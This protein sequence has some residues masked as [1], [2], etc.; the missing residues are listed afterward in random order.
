MPREDAAE[1]MKLQLVRDADDDERQEGVQWRPQRARIPQSK[2][3]IYNESQ[4]SCVFNRDWLNFKPIFFVQFSIFFIDQ[5]TGWECSEASQFLLKRRPN[6]SGKWLFSLISSID[7]YLF[8]LWNERI[9]IQS[10]VNCDKN[11]CE[12]SNPIN[13]SRTGIEKFSAITHEIKFLNSRHCEY[14]FV[15]SY[16]HMLMYNSVWQLHSKRAFFTPWRK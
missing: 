11:Y 15:D 6:R 13:E 10:I 3:I 14:L 4:L 7:Y 1:A 12:I 8:L 5:G 16:P 2:R 9:V